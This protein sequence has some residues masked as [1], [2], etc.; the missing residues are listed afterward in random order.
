MCMRERESDIDTC[1]E[2][3]C[4]RLCCGLGRREKALCV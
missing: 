4:V 3:D 2:I 1:I